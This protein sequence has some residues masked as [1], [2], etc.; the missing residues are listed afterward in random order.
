LVIIR[1]EKLNT[2]K[3]EKFTERAPLGKQAE[4]AKVRYKISR[5]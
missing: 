4:F 2:W 3:P 5:S 1:G